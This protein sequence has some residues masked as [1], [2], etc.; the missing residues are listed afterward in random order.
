MSTIAPLRKTS[1]TQQLFISMNEWHFCMH[2]TIEDRIFPS[3]LS[4]SAA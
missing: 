2:F 4:R 3:E 1:R